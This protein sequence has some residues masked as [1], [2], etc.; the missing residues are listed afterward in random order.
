M[1][2]DLI[3][4]IREPREIPE[5]KRVRRTVDLRY[6]KSQISLE[7]ATQEATDYLKS[8]GFDMFRLEFDTQMDHGDADDEHYPV[9]SIIG[10]RMETAEEVAERVRRHEAYNARKWADHN[11][12]LG[13]IAR[14][15]ELDRITG[16]LTLGQLKAIPSLAAPEAAQPLNTN[17]S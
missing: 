10:S 1:D 3:T 17:R 2:L 9:M 6:I 5:S 14:R 13:A 11:A 16:S 15:K 8:L 7:K 4:I 12:R